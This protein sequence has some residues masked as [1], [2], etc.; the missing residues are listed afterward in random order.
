VI[1][2]KLLEEA[3]AEL[4]LDLF[5]RRGLGPGCRLRTDSP[6]WSLAETR[7]R[8]MLASPSVE[9]CPSSNTSSSSASNTTG[10]ANAKTA[11]YDAV[12]VDQGGG[13]AGGLR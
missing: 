6:S 10:S 2:E 4:R 1:L 9:R 8:P 7:K 11:P 12:G 3:W 13:G 5:G